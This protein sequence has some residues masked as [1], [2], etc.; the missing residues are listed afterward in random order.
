MA[1]NAI[2]FKVPLVSPAGEPVI[3]GTWSLLK[4]GEV[5]HGTIQ[6]EDSLIQA[7]QIIADNEST[8]KFTTQQI[9]LFRSFLCA[10]TQLK[11]AQTNLFEVFDSGMPLSRSA[12]YIWRIGMF[13]R[14]ANAVVGV[15]GV[16]THLWL[17]IASFNVTPIAGATMVGSLGSDI[18]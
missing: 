4:S 15:A 1:D 11:N 7:L 14:A 5:Y 6:P 3:A 16:A 8:K 17:A 10:I 9:E 18:A 13:D 2:N 12:D